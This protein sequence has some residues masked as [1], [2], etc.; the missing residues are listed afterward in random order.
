MINL[1]GVSG[2]RQTNLG[3]KISGGLRMGG[4]VRVEVSSD[5]EI[6]F[7]VLRCTYLGIAL[8]I[9]SCHVLD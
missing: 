2:G 5:V 8:N 4:C 9:N 3:G 6:I 7:L 1:T